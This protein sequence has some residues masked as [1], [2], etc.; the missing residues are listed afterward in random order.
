M[1]GVQTCALPIC[2]E[3]YS[4]SILF[5]VWFEKA[6][7]VAVKNDIMVK[8]QERFEQEGIE[9]P[10][11]HQLLLSSS[12]SD[13][14]PVVLADKRKGTARAGSGRRTSKGGAASAGGASAGAAPGGT[15]SGGGR[16]D[17]SKR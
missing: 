1:T 7:F 14:F 8:I 12:V 10:Y 9:I 13:P 6:D 17:G 16:F 3:E 2:F 15:A 4:I 5:G 11:P